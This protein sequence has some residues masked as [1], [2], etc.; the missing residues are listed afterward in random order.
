MPVEFSGP[1]L[2]TSHAG[3]YRPLGFGGEPVHATYRRLIAVIESRLGPAAARYLA[4]P[5]VH[6]ASRSIGWHATVDGPV[7]RWSELTPTE[8]ATLGPAFEAL[9][10]KLQGL[11]RDLE[12]AGP[13]GR[14][15]QE[16]F[17]HA[18]RLALRSPWIDNLFF[19][20]DQPVLALW[21]FEGGTKPAFDS[22]SFRPEPQGV[23]AVEV[24]AV[25][26][27]R[28]PWWR[29]LL[30]L[31]GLLL[32]LLLLLLVLHSCLSVPVPLIDKFLPQ[33]LQ[34][35]PEAPVPPG[36]TNPNAPSG[37]TILGPN[38]TTTVVPGGTVTGPNGT[39]VP[40]SDT[41]TTV[42]GT[43]EG[44]VPGTTPKT[45]GTE[46]GQG[47]QDQGTQPLAPGEQNKPGQNQTE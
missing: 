11:V 38:G 31:L 9:Q 25:V 17:G 30:W 12:A 37:T 27:A 23:P 7:R 13:S 6:E 47:S 46:P 44:T 10:A 34:P 8:Q 33:S 43:N 1:L 35:A 20:G 3:E 36:E 22:L 41:G 14:G 39:T 24:T 26:A 45:N 18:L 32:L 40:G 16:N 19:V 21:G 5:E 15:A 29:W 28:R 2:L 42:P 4:R